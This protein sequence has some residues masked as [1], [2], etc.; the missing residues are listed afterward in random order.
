VN[1]LRPMCPFLDRRDARCADRLTLT[2]LR[3]AFRLCAGN[4]D[5]CTNYH[6]IRMDDL[7]REQ[8]RLVAQPA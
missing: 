1:A 2:N 3:Q 4:H 8:E 6:Q 5:F 7:R